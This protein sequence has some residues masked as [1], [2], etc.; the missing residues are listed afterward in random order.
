MKNHLNEIST[1]LWL[2]LYQQYQT[3]YDG[4]LYYFSS[5]DNMKKFIENPDKYVPQYG[6]FCAVAMFFN[7]KK[8]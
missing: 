4:A 1:A 6:G 7:L 2:A 5:K 8:S 3:A